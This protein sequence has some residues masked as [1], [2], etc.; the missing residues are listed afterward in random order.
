[1]IL[2]GACHHPGLAGPPHA[3]SS[4]M[5]SAL[6][7][8]VFS[9]HQLSGFCNVFTASLCPHPAQPPAQVPVR[10]FLI[11]DSRSSRARASPAATAARRPLSHPWHVQTRVETRVTTAWR[12]QHRG[13]IVTAGT[14]SYLLDTATQQ[15]RDQGPW[16]HVTGSVS[17]FRHRIIMSTPLFQYHS[18][19][20]LCPLSENLL[21]LRTWSPR[22]NVPQ[23][24]PGPDIKWWG[25]QQYLQLRG[26]PSFGYN[27]SVLPSHLDDGHRVVSGQHVVIS[28]DIETGDHWTMG[29]LD[30]D[31]GTWQLWAHRLKYFL[32][33][34][35]IFVHFK[36][37]QAREGWD[38][39][40]VTLTLK[41]C[42]HTAS[43]AACVSIL[44]TLSTRTRNNEI[45]SFCVS[46]VIAWT[47]N[48][49]LVDRLRA[50]W[51]RQDGMK[52]CMRSPG[53][54]HHQ[55]ADRCVVHCLRSLHRG[56][57]GTPSSSLAFI[58]TKRV[59]YTVYC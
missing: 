14:M 35:N 49:V 44:I 46:R 32:S 58:R 52:Y 59:K 41:T 37:R 42:V 20:I 29:T 15:H 3:I 21:T 10:T 51:W 7:N 8:I 50:G 1:M 48:C 19:V 13:S 11:P 39:I 53:A 28:A 5:H 27:L 26:D 40:A 47:I 34:S 43:H 38:N 25:Q 23:F 22:W 16:T 56:T 4:I 12:G 31:T 30:T 17:H 57:L 45:S 2:S 6:K 33:P 36:P 18:K 54:G 55:T 24:V 9:L